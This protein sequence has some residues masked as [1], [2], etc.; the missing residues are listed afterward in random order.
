MRTAEMVVA[1]SSILMT[2]DGVSGVGGGDNRGVRAPR[3]R[4]KFDFCH[5]S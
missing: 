2:A 5:S 3:I 4:L 1:T